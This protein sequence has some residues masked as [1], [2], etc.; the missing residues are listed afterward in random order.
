MNTIFSIKNVSKVYQMGEVTVQTLHSVNLD[1]LEGELD[2]FRTQLKRHL[3]TNLSRHLET[4][5]DNIYQDALRYVTKKTRLQTLPPTC[6]YTL[7]QLL[8]DLRI[9]SIYSV[10]LGT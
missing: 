9:D 7:E 1:F 8:Q 3:T 10:I 6:P 4:E 5:F 2:G